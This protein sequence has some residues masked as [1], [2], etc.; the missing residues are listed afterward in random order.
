MFGGLI[1]R[2]YLAPKRLKAIAPEVFRSFSGLYRTVPCSSGAVPGC[3]R[4]VPDWTVPCCSGGVP[5]CFVLFRGVP[6]CSG[7]VPGCS[8][9]VPDCSGGVPGCSG[10]LRG[11]PG[12]SGVFRGVPECSGVFRVVP[13]IRISVPC[14]STCRL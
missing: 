11:V 1:W 12:C 4:G 10:V 8:G 2:A 9:G 14:F 6:S 3:F 5:G 13:V 7:G